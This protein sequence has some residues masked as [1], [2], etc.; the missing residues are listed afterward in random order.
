VGGGS[1]RFLPAALAADLKALAGR[2]G[3][4]P[5]ML[6]LAGFLTLLYRYTGEEDILVRFA[7][8]CSPLPGDP[9]TGWITRGR[10][11]T[12]HRRGCKRALELELERSRSTGVHITDYLSTFRVHWEDDYTLTI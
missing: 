7:K 10:G 2:E 4:T 6:L 8:C 12:V 1:S 9:V 11:V 5:F 3:V